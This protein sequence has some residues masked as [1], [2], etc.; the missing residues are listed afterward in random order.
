MESVDNC[1][2]VC[3]SSVRARTPIWFLIVGRIIGSNLTWL[4]AVFISR[5]IHSNDKR[6]YSFFRAEDQVRDNWVV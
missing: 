5:T 3:A 6:L 2:Y 1:D 4:I